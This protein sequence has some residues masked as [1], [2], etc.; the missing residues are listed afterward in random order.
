MPNRLCMRARLQFIRFL[1]F[2]RFCTYQRK[3]DYYYY[4]CMNDYYLTANICIYFF[5]SP[6]LLTISVSVCLS[7]CVGCFVGVCVRCYLLF[8]IT[9]SALIVTGFIHE[10]KFS[11]PKL[12]SSRFEVQIFIENYYLTNSALFITKPKYFHY[13]FQLNNSTK[14][15]LNCFLFF[16]FCSNFSDIVSI[17]HR[18]SAK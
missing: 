1:R 15:L 4:V 12:F 3:F 6:I 8:Y 10:T 2:S 11:V 14:C 13:I 9:R 5:P 7:P 17:G 16:L 18:R